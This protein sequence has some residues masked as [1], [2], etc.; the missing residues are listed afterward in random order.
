MSHLAALN[1]VN[2]R[3]AETKEIVRAL[4]ID[5]E[6]RL[7]RDPENSYDA[8]AIKVLNDDGEFLGFVEKDV[9]AEIAD[10]LDNGDECTCVV[11]GF[12]SDIKPQLE[13][14]FAEDES[15]EDDGSD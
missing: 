1:G 14:T 11:V 13:I 5:D 2:F 10:R 6:L 3:P 7:E 15:A 4:E 8:N 9:A 12:L